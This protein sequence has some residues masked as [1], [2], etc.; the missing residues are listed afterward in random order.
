MASQQGVSEAGSE[1]IRSTTELLASLTRRIMIAV[2]ITQL[3]WYGFAAAVWPLT[4][5]WSVVGI[6]A[7]AVISTVVSIRLLVWQPSLGAVVWQLGMAAAI[8]WAMH[9]YGYPD[10]AFLYALLPLV[11]AI[12]RGW[13]G[14]LAAEAGIGIAVVIGAPAYS[15]AVLPEWHIVAVLAA[16]ALS[17]CIGWAVRDTVATGVGWYSYSLQQSNENLAVARQHRADLMRAQRCLDQAYTRL[18]HTNA[19]LVAAWKAADEAEHLKGEMLAT[20]SHELRTPLNLIVGFAEMMVTS[21]E[22]YDNTLLPGP[23]RTDL[24]T[25]YNNARHLLALVDDVLDLAIAQAG[26]INL[27]REEFSVSDLVAQSV[28]MLKDYVAAKRLSLNVSIQ[29]D[30]PPI[31]AD[32]LRIRQVLLNLLVNAVRFTDEGHISIRV[33]KHDGDIT[34]RVTDT[35]QGI[36]ANELPQVFDEFRSGQSDTQSWHSG[37]GL[38]LPISKRFIQLHGGDM[39]VESRLGHGATFWFTLPVGLDAQV[40]RRVA[41]LQRGRPAGPGIDARPP[42]VVVGADAAVKRLCQRRLSDFEVLEAADIVTGLIL[43]RDVKAVAVLTPDVAPVQLA[44]DDPIIVRCSLPSGAQAASEMGAFQT[45][46][47]PVFREDLDATL[48]ALSHAPRRVL[49]VA[50]DPDLAR[51]F[52]R[53]LRQRTSVQRCHEA[54][55]VQE[56]SEM[57]TT[58]HPDLVVL[59]LSAVDR[60]RDGALNTLSADTR[61]VGA[62]LLVVSDQEHDYLGTLLPGDIGFHKPAGLGLDE[63]LSAVA[64][65]LSALGKRS[66]T[67][68]APMRQTRSA[69]SPAW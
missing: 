3:V 43:A 6:T 38:G 20:I 44:P 5:D 7:L 33:T 10:I 59:D 9:A 52:R 18:E 16:G 24:N 55:S 58:L 1:M 46:T 40:A 64:G 66:L 48:D 26:K 23:Y 25:I 4:F 14:G 68:R 61:A 28:D 42:V 17:A 11:A 22:S 53:L 32:R 56:A 51:L 31:Y 41:P 49:I 34:V 8:L 12:N 60:H 45:L 69:E 57:V 67:A 37:S 2:S 39:G 15:G 47:K 30:L 13:T 63:L 62:A 65:V 27:L 54:F 21:P 35:G 50:G 19:A 29:P 36:S